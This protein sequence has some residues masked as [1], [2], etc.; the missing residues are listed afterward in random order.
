MPEFIKKSLR[1][2]VKRWQTSNVP[3]PPS[4]MSKQQFKTWMQRIMEQEKVGS[5]DALDMMS[6]LPQTGRLYPEAKPM[7]LTT[8]ES[9]P[10]PQELPSS[11]ISP[12]ELRQMVINRAFQPGAEGATL[13]PQDIQSIMK[14]E[15]PVSRD[16]TRLF[17]TEQVLNRGGVSGAPNYKRLMLDPL[18]A[19][20]MN[21]ANPERYPQAPGV[22]SI[23]D[24]RIGKTPEEGIAYE[25]LKLKGLPKNLAKEKETV[26]RE[27]KIPAN[28]PPETISPLLTLVMEADD[29]W[30][31]TLGGMRGTGGKLWNRF[32]ETS[33]GRKRGEKTYGSAKEYFSAMYVKWTMD[34]AKFMRA[35][36]TEANFFNNIMPRNQ[37]IKPGDLMQSLIPP[38]AA[39]STLGGGDI[40]KFLGG[41]QDANQP[42]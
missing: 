17:D 21:L 7:P 20:K 2:I 32:Y 13:N 40:M 30:R 25:R 28:A 27:A 4:K 41:G 18:E 35:Y 34:P 24:L 10:S 12:D 42:Y 37:G 9:V 3:K 36:P 29:V 23:K 1:E 5:E 14:R 33:L 38:A 31:H 16:V 26:M 22:G 11:Q 8:Q 19:Q 15:P 6:K 39:G